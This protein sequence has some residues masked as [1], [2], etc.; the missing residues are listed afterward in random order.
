VRPADAARTRRVASEV[1]RVY[2]TTME[3]LIYALEGR[4]VFWSL[5]KFVNHCA[6]AGA[7][8]E[9]AL[10]YIM[11]AIG[12]DAVA[13]PSVS[14]AWARRAVEMMERC[15]TPRDVAYTVSRSSMLH[16]GACRWEEAD[17]AI[18]RAREIAREV[19]DF[20]TLVDCDALAA[21]LAQFQGQFERALAFAQEEHRLSLTSGNWQTECWSLMGQGD[22]LVRLGREHE[23]A[24]LYE[25]ALAKIDQDV[26][27]SEAVMGWG[28]LALARLRM[29]DARG[30]SECADRAVS[31]LLA[32]APVVYYMQNA[33]AATAE[34][35]L[36]L[37]EARG[38]SSSR[39]PLA[40]RAHQACLSLRRFARRFPVGRPFA[41]LWDG[42]LAW[43]DGRPRRAM[44][45]WQRAL[46]LAERLDTPYERARA[47]LEIGRHLPPDAV[48]RRRHLNEAVTLLEQLGCA[49][50]LE[51]ARAALART[52]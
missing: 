30:A 15:G 33:T 52:A 44:R 16:L 35:F 8:P 10:G 19:M 48:E 41:C 12:A 40:I 22:A 37:L 6:P 9:L 29:G 34:V 27:R 36:S 21:I 50:D 46:T 43:L 20:R 23:A 18:N 14:K 51:R 49:P 11:S 32:T 5:V 45:L 24:S 3:S 25:S 13:L 1:G 31:H 17:A 2:L 39:E 4:A 28:G 47:H 26:M 42:L 38:P 7:S